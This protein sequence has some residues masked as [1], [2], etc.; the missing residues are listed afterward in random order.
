MF[1]LCLSVILS[2]CHTSFLDF[3]CLCFH[4]SVWN[5]VASLH[6]NVYFV[7][8][9]LLSHELLP[10]LQNSLSGLF[11]A[12]LS[13]IWMKLGCKL[14]YEELQFKFDF[15]HDWLNFP[16]SSYSTVQNSFSGFF[17]ALYFRISKWKLVA[18]IHMKS[19]NS[20]LTSVTVYLLFMSN[21][22]LFKSPFPDLSW[23]CFH[24]EVCSNLWYEKLQIKFDFRH[25]WP[26]F[27]ELFFYCF[28]D[29]PF[30]RMRNYR[31]NLKY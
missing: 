17:L 8:V 11:L 16:W 26:T 9:D 10:F 31:I 3:P 20:S 2:V 4:V 14:S 22:P 27:Y 6:I 12:M 24:N 30:F 25:K 23:L 13:N 21:C 1:A 28:R 7:T 18:S 29:F 15:C 5:L 19:Y